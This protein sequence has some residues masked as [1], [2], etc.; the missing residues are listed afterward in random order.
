MSDEKIPSQITADL[1]SVKELINNVANL[2][3][4]EHSNEFEKIHNKLKDALA[5]LDGV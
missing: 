1:S 3:I 5:N 4:A 2:S